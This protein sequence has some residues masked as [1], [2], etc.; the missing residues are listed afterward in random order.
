MGESLSVED[1][2]TKDLRNSSFLRGVNIH[3]ERSSSLVMNRS[4]SPKSSS[5]DQEIPIVAVR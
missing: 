1:G 3:E 4:E 5:D 2:D